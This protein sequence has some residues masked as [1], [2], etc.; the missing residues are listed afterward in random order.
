[1][2]GTQDSDLLNELIAVCH[3]GE[4]FY[5]HAA[6]AVENSE[7]RSLFWE[8]ADSRRQI[9]EALSDKLA[10][11]EGEGRDGTALS[12]R[13]RRLYAELEARLSRD[14]DVRYVSELEHREAH[15]LYNFRQ[16]ISS[17][18][19]TR[20]AQELARHLASIQVMHDRMHLIREEIEGR[21]RR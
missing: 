15:A 13:M 18:Q 1:M 19:N 20:L 14:S 9:A 8:M 5:R 2:S 4:C 17:V 16:S 6:K 12:Q 11:A 7:L 3:D 10:G 21:Q